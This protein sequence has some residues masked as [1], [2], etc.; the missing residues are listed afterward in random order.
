MFNDD[1]IKSYNNV[2]PAI[3]ARKAKSILGEKTSTSRL[4]IAQCAQEI[5]ALLLGEL[6]SQSIAGQENLAHSASKCANS[7]QKKMRLFSPDNPEAVLILAENLAAIQQLSGQE[8]ENLAF[9]LGMILPQNTG[10]ILN[11]AP[12]QEGHATEKTGEHSKNTV[13]FWKNTLEGIFSVANE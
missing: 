6:K 5:L 7:L 11:T 4:I 13:S 2:K 8:Q 12:R 1:F 9:N 3:P 10:S